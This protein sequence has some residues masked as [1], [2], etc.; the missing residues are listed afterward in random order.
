MVTLLDEPFLGLLPASAKAAPCP[1]LSEK[2]ASLETETEARL[3]VTDD[4]HS[5]ASITISSAT[6]TS[7][8]TSAF[9]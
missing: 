9:P 4:P 5:P 8:C 7:L 2:R 6:I 3:P 1:L